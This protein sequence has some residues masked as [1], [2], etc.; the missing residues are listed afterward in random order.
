LHLIETFLLKNL[1]KCSFNKNTQ[2]KAL[3]E[4][5]EQQKQEKEENS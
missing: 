3:K 5:E 4:Q 1:E 2:I